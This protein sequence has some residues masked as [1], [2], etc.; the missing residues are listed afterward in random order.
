M[1][2]A[3]LDAMLTLTQAAQLLGVSPQLIADWR[4]RGRI[5]RHSGRWYRLGDLLDVE[6]ETRRNSQPGAFKRGEHIT[7]NAA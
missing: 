6:R 4:T 3:N 1:P 7:A 2:V 5:T